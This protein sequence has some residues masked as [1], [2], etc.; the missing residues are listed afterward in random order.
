MNKTKVKKN[1]Y[2]KKGRD[3]KVFAAYKIDENGNLIETKVCKGILL[4]NEMTGKNEANISRAA[5]NPQSKHS[6]LI[7]KEWRFL[8]LG[9]VKTIDPF[10]Q[11]HWKKKA[12]EGWTK[13]GENW[14]TYILLSKL[15][16]L[17]SED[18]EMLG[19]KHTKKLNN[20]LLNL[21]ILN[22]K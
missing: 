1:Q 5:N 13:H 3:V 10:Y 15:K 8:T 17:M 21:L 22:K 11:E 6:H 12:K 4:V 14:K 20:T 2:V 18:N 19:E 7:S 16:N 9:V